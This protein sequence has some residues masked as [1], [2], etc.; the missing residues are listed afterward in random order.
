MSATW[1]ASVSRCSRPLPSPPDSGRGGTRLFSSRNDSIVEYTV[2]PPMWPRCTSTLVP[3]L[4]PSIIGPSC[5]TLVAVCDTDEDT[6]W[7]RSN[8]T[9]LAQAHARAAAYGWFYPVSCALCDV[10]C[11]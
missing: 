5:P 2:R 4:K 1:L 7:G 11:G 3:E 8:A 10:G 6:G 9:A